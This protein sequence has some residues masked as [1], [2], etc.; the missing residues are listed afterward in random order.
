MQR[1]RFQLTAV[2]LSIVDNPAQVAYLR[3]VLGYLLIGLLVAAAGTQVGMMPPVLALVAGHPFI[4]MFGMIGLIMWA[5]TASTGPRAGTAYYVFTFA[6]GLLMAPIIFVTLS[7]F[8]GLQTLAMAGGITVVN[9]LALSAYAW[10]SKRDFSF[11]G[12]FLITGLI[13]MIVAQLLNAFWLH[14]PLLESVVPMI[15]ILL[16]N[17][18]ILYDLSRILNN[19]RSIPPTA[20][21]LMLFL[22]IFNLFLAWLRVLDR[23]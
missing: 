3:K 21:A 17:G 19:A 12:G 23:D 2:P 20:A 13:T 10:I 1:G 5:T 15:L 7:R 11:M 8:N 22:D 4:G 18:F 9:T 6:M 14:S 16:F